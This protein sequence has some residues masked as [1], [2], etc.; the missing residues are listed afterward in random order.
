MHA[1][2]E[3]YYQK[4]LNPRLDPKYEDYEGVG[5]WYPFNVGKETYEFFIKFFYQKIL[6]PQTACNAPDITKIPK[7]V[8]DRIKKDNEIVRTEGLNHFWEKVARHSVKEAKKPT[9]AVHK[10]TAPPAPAAVPV[11]PKEPSMPPPI[12]RSDDASAESKD[13]LAKKQQEFEENIRKI[14]SAAHSYKQN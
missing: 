2:H 3:P 4:I 7:D 8:R 13:E 14:R 11:P 10:N 9:P 6:K 5:A 12:V 1:M